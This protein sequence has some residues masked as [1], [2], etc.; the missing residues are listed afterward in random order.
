MG[1]STSS[2]SSELANA[3]GAPVPAEV[4]KKIVVNREDYQCFNKT[5]EIFVRHNGE[6]KGQMIMIDKC[7]DSIIF[8]LDHVGSIT[9]DECTDCVLVT[10][11]VSS[12]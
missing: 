4:K 2:N 5:N 3:P 10:G 12:R 9:M 11:P 6:V 1:C 8:L 7:V